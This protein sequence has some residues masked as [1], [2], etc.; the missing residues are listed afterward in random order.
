MKSDEN[1]DLGEALLDQERE[2]EWPEIIPL[3]RDTDLP[4][5]PLEALPGIGGEM[6][7][8]VAES[9]QVDAGMPASLYLAV[10]S[11]CGPYY[12]DLKSHTEQT[13]I[14]VASI[15]GSGE[16]KSATIGAM[17]RPL[18][19]YQAEL[20][21][22]ERPRVAEELSRHKVRE[23]RL[24]KLQ[25]KAAEC[26]DPMERRNL[27]MEAE[28]VVRE[29]GENPVP[30]LPVLAV[31]DIT[32][33][34][35]GVL[36]TENQ[37]HLSV[38]SSEGGLFGLIAGRY[39]KQQ[40]SG[41]FDLYLK[42]YSGDSWSSHRIGREPR[43]M[44]RPSLSIGLTVQPDVIEEIGRNKSFHGRGLL[45]R[46]NYDLCKPQA[47][48]RAR[49]TTPIPY[50]LEQRYHAHITELLALSPRRK[51]F[52]LSP[53][54]QAVWDEFYDDI[55]MQLGEG[56]D[57][58]HIASWGSKLPGT[59]A[60]IA[61]LLHLAE[62]GGVAGERPISVTFVTKSCT[63]AAYFRE[64]ALAV[65]DNMHTDPRIELA[66]KVLSVIEKHGLTTFK[67]R[68]IVRRSGLKHFDDVLTGTGVLEERGYIRRVGSTYSGAGRPEA[69]T[70]QVNPEVVQI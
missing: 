11:A 68:D 33:E 70:F 57:L 44:T 24:A 67:V 39:S 7:Q 46:F 41:G 66:Q 26:D 20:Q 31:D 36:M 27:E 61:G 50:D 63:I 54:A 1:F 28:A 38:F 32:T 52:T 6:V 51:T 34:A 8:V 30:S 25:K 29:I 53:E 21:S 47:G 56:G 59:A 22:R 58:H 5:F 69:I 12:V 18:Y 9:Y 65:F 64:H 45:A 43:T 60:R 17:T 14:N 19:D 49:Q 40:E 23:S 10:L 62:H 55:E 35:L 4:D 48:R 15:A 13:S 42:S 3:S 2:R 37:E 16:R